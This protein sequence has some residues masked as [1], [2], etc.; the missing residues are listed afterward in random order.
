MPTAL[1]F[2][3]Q[4]ALVTGGAAGIGR[5]HCELLAERGA[6]VVVNG[7]FRPSGSGPEQD[8]AAFIRERGGEAVA[9]NGSVTDEDAVLRMVQT[10]IDS[11]GR[12]DI[13]VNNA[14]TG[15]TTLTTPAAPD[16]RLDGAL[17]VHL[18]GTMRVTRAAWSHLAA[19]GAG[20]ILN[21]GSA[22]AFGVQT[23][24]GYEVGYSV[25]KSALFAVTRQMAGEGAASGIKA[26]L[27]LPW[28]FSPMAAK[29]LE[30]SALGKYMKEKLDPAK[31]AAAC[32]YL[33]H[34]D[35]PVTGQFISAAGGR[36]A[37]VVFATSR[38]YCNPD[39]TPE[40]VRD[41]WS[42]IH[43]EADAD[44]AIR[45][46]LELTGLQGEFRLIRKALG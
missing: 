6:K 17:D 15:Q 10:A 45:D 43:G 32:L 35:C 5:A 23:P 19:A 46:A 44:G 27:L 4:V 12:I 14:G 2:D 9:V 13:L 16:E 34:H 38:G 26:N 29:D 30:R 41:N 25:A 8:V 28:A 1:R 11:F 33:L 7:N 3:G 21:T 20:R 22:C 39:L 42:E 31:V 40:D 37:R 24:E 36:V 18:R